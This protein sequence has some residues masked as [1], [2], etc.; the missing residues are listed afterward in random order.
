MMM[1]KYQQIKTVVRVRKRV[2]PVV[3]TFTKKVTYSAIPVTLYNVGIEHHDLSIQEI[4][5]TLYDNTMIELISSACKMLI[6]IK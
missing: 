4:Q 6:H 2:V 3:K 1:K 5:K